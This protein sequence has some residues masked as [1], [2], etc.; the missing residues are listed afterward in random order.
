[1]KIRRAIELNLEGTRVKYFPATDQ[2]QICAALITQFCLHSKLEGSLFVV[3]CRL[4]L[5]FQHF[6]HTLLLL[7]NWEPYEVVK[8]LIN[9]ELYELH[10]NFIGL[11]N[12]CRG[13]FRADKLQ[14]ESS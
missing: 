8:E 6:K 13:N 9:S 10:N 2:D 7:L 4:R 11:P 14:V 5:L 12:I 1:M 3:A